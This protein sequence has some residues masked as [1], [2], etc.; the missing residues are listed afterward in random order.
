MKGP[1]LEQLA[2]AATIIVAAVVA[3]TLLI[4]TTPPMQGVNGAYK[5]G[6]RVSEIP[7]LDAYG[8]WVWVLAVSTNCEYCVRS[9]P[10]Y[11]TLVERAAVISPSVPVIAV[12]HQASADLLKFLESD[13]VPVRAVV[14]VGR[15][16]RLVRQTPTI[17]LLDGAGT[18]IQSWVG[19]LSQ[20][21]QDEVL[22][23]VGSGPGQ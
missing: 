10:F 11:R 12:G 6:E 15:E 9:K 8:S 7:R 1:S 22:R 21:K 19:L 18:V 23:A 20:D 16:S 13:G 4:R 5:A 3:Y 2:N 14:P 17:Y